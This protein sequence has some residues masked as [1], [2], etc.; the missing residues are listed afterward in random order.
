[1]KHCTEDDLVL[2]HYGESRRPADVERHLEECAAC[3]ATHRAIATTLSM[4][5]EPK[6]P[7]RGDRY[8]LEVWQRVRHQLPPQ[9][10][11][12]WFMW[13]RWDRFAAAGAVAVF[14]AA[15]TAAFIAGRAGRVGPRPEPPRPTIAQSTTDVG[16]DSDAR[17]RLAAI[18]DHLERSERV[19]LDVVNLM[20]GRGD[21]VDVSDEQAWAADL[22]DA[23]RLYR[24]AAANAGDMMVAT[25]LDDLERNLLD[26]VHGPSALTPAQL[27]QLRVR[28]DAAA[29]L[30]RVR[31]LHDE[32]R[33]RESAPAPIRKTT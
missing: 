22:V 26:I 21:R 20:G 29:L 6:V 13:F 15:V 27:E 12:W 18:S 17:V 2:Y 5:V 32:L 10:G 23:N 8:G 24:Q 1:V 31:V 11:P 33:E 19:L 7:E 30:F 25:V 16:G 4:I 14:C 3:A 9:D 28:L